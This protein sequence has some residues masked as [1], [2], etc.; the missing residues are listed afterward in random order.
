MPKKNPNPSS[1]PPEPTLY[2]IDGV[3]VFGR[4]DAQGQPSS[5]DAIDTDET[6][7]R[8]I[9]DR[10]HRQGFGVVR[11]R[12]PRAGKVFYRLKATWPGPGAPPDDPF[13]RRGFAPAAGR[14]Q[15]KTETTP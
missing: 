14:R 10:L 6:K 15:R 13:D 12:S 11:Q 8:M 4:K 3:P 7:I 1:K 2:E 9:A 5:I